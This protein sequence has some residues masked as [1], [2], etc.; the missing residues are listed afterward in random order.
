MP[1]QSFTSKHEWHVPNCLS[2]DRFI[3]LRCLLNTENFR[4]AKA[5]SQTQQEEDILKQVR[6]RKSWSKV[7]MHYQS[8][9]I[10]ISTI[11]YSYNTWNNFYKLLANDMYQY[12]KR[13]ETFKT[14][15]LFLHFL[16]RI[17]I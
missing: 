9:N 11:E 5:L 12:C 13:S 16:F 1:L 8:F 3:P 10:T 14:K 15:I 4:Y 6:R 2:G 7:A 17:C